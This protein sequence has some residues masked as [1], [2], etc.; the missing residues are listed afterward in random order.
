MFFFL[1]KMVFDRICVKLVSKICY[2]T[3]ASK[4]VF[5]HGFY[6]IIYKIQFFLT[7]SSFVLTKTPYFEQ[8]CTKR[9]FLDN[10]MQHKLQFKSFQK[11]VLIFLINGFDQ[12]VSK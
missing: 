10:I 11:S 2:T 3:H 1:T 7:F 9:V 12:I 5:L 6:E 8:V 4:N